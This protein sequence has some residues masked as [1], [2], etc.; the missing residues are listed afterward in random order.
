MILLMLEPTAK[1]NV[2]FR[3]W[4][5]F[6]SLCGEYVFNLEFGREIIKNKLNKLKKVAL[7]KQV[8]TYCA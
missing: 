3:R 5:I 6:S 4:S 7:K 8:W 1:L 2:T